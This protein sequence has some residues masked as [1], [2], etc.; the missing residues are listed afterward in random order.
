MQ[1]LATLKKPKH[2][3]PS[4]SH[5]AKLIK[6]TVKLLSI[7]ISFFLFIALFTY[8]KADGGWSHTG[9]AA[10]VH[11]SAG[12]AGAWFS[13][14]FLY[15][16]GY[17][18]FLFPILVV[19]ITFQLIKDRDTKD[20]DYN[21]LS[22]RFLGF[23]LM[24]LSLSAII[25]ITMLSPSEYLPFS[26]GGILGDFVGFGV[27]EIFNFIGALIVLVSLSL[28]G[29]TLLSGL[30]WFELS[31]LCVAHFS[32]LSNSFS[33]YVTKTISSMYANAQVWLKARK[34]SKAEKVKIN[35]PNIH[36][37]KSIT[38]KKLKENLTPKMMQKPIIAKRS[39]KDN[40][41]IKKPKLSGDA[42]LPS[43]A[44]LDTKSD[45]DKIE[46][47]SSILEAL[48][49]E[50]EQKLLDFG[51]KVNVVGVQ[52]GPVVTRFE[53]ELAPGIK[54]SR[55]TTLASD[56][57]RSLSVIS[58]RV[59]EV[60]PGKSY[61]GLEIPNP[62]RETV[63]LSE[64]LTTDQYKNSHA[65]L[66]LA[67]GKD[68]S[69]Y[70]VIV[71]L[72][73]MPHL[74]VAG[75][76][77]SGKSVGINTMLI[78]L[79]YKSSPEDVRL[80]M[81]DPKM[82]ELSVYEDIPHLLAPVVTDMKEAANA[83]RWCVAE[84]ERR[85]SLMAQLG[86][87]NLEGY[88]KKI[89]AGDTK[90]TKSKDADEDHLT[91]LPHIVIVIDEFADMIMVVGKKVEQ[92]IARLAQKARASGIH[93]I[94]ATQRPSVDVITGLIKSNIPT[95][96]A[97]QVSSRIDS[98]T[99]LD[100][101][102]AEQLL[103]HGDMLYL[104]PGMGAPIRVHGA[105]V[106][107][108]EVHKVTADLKKQGKPQYLE[109]IVDYSS[110]LSGGA[111]DAEQDDLYDEAIAFIQETKKVSVSSIQRKFRIGYNRAASMVDAMEAAGAIS[112]ME[113]NGS[114]EVLI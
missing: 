111:N 110:S 60:I 106:T 71:D 13:D 4:D 27:M 49:S 34:V 88:N 22:I 51:I 3:T 57:A 42:P 15:V 108:D 43:L 109:A 83:L 84:M 23:I 38:I 33:V 97:Y 68:I 75:T 67:L 16:F 69:G 9:Y 114:R 24:M 96:I 99:I 87:R 32:R 92:L 37:K 55:I 28:V 50:V 91:H 40:F 36:T 62:S 7:A 89:A 8:D 47:D 64:V 29:I 6:E 103:G 58:V 113:S 73:K 86:V 1:K 61:V 74:L 72:A 48:S 19:L 5:I 70:P 85:Y 90:T 56:L 31:T 66:G 54:A 26:S 65:T 21:L 30:S 46:I 39:Q 59:V 44:L 35:T 18:A 107:D 80:I 81:V 78:S 25:S 93:M 17:L 10:I 12:K 79:L 45:G 105:Y 2:V 95:R 11:N 102:G 82:L 14:L 52:P 98:R 94:L 76:T 53:M 104:P 77:G 112:P 41:D 20:V 100:Q 63:L 101:Q